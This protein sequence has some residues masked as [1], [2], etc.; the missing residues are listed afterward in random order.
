LIGPTGYEHA[1]NHALS[2]STVVC[3][4]MRAFVWDVSITSHVLEMAELNKRPQST[5][6]KETFRNIT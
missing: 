1:D 6:Y 2:H 5:P 4:P 3:G